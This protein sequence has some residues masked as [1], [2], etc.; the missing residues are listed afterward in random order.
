[1][2]RPQ[3]GDLRLRPAGSTGDD[4]LT[5]KR[6]DGDT[7]AYKNHNHSEDFL[8]CVRSRQEPLSNVDVTH[9]ATILGLIA[10]IAARLQKPLKWEPQTET[11]IGSE[12][13]NRLLAR[14]LHNGWQLTI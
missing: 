9:H 3:P 7:I 10:E 8:H 4:I 6:R 12:D 5:V 14:Q 1:M 13:A 2:L 11:F